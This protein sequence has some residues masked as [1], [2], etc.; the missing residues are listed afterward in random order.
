MRTVYGESLAT[1]EDTN[2]RGQ[3]YRTY[4]T[5]GMLE[6][7]EFDFKGNPLSQTRRFASDFKTRPDRIALASVTDPATIQ[8]LA[9]SLLESETFTLSMTLDALDRVVTSTTPDSSIT[10]Y[11]YG[12]GGLLQ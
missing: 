1:P 7:T 8:G 10:S 6:A 2:H 12:E 4:D 11:S 3:A 5:A 9:N